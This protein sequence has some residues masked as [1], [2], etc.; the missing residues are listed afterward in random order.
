MMKRPT[1]ATE[2]NLNFNLLGRHRCKFDVINFSELSILQPGAKRKV[3]DEI[4]FRC[5]N[6]EDEF[7]KFLFFQP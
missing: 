6:F 2:I 1:D 4:N 5:K 3:V 7:A